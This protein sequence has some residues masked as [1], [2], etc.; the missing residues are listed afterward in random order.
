MDIKTIKLTLSAICSYIYT[1]FE[2]SFPLLQ[3]LAIVMIIDFVLG[4]WQAFSIGKK[5][6]P[7][8]FLSKLKEAGLFVVVLAAAIFINP[9]WEQYGLKA[10]LIA[11]Y[12]ISAYGFYH[13]FS[14]LQNAGKMGFPLASVLQK[15]IE[16]K[17]T[18][19]ANINKKEENNENS[20]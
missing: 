5:F 19:L 6:D 10:H 11:N 2:P 20:K 1:L 14:I 17:S 3:A 4:V 7:K 16:S 15:F 9:L 8:K 18:D 13:F 12:L